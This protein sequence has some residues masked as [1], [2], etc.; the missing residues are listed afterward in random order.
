MSVTTCSYPIMNE[1]KSVLTNQ[2]LWGVTV[3]QL[4]LAFLLLILG[5]LMRR[6]IPRLFQG[7]L[8]KYARSSRF[9]WDN[10]LVELIPKPLSYVVQLGIWYVTAT[11]LTLPQSPLN[12][13]RIV[14]QGFEIALWVMLTWVFFRLIDVVTRV[15]DRAADRTDTKLDDQLVPLIRK[16]TKVLLAVIITV[17]VL[18][19]LDIEVTSLIAS[20]GIGGLVLALAAKDTVAN[21]FGSVVVFTDQPFQIGDWIEVGG[22]EGIV[23]EVGFRTT[24]IRKFDK[25][26]VY[27]P[28]QVFTA[29]SIKNYSRREVRRIKFSVGLGYDTTPDQMRAFLEGVRELLKNLEG[30]TEDTAVAF[31][32]MGASSLNVLVMCYSRSSVWTEYMAVQ[33]ELFLKIMDLVESMGLEI[34]FPT[35]TIYVREDAGNMDQGT[36]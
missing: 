4:C 6:V 36:T 35:Q 21:F 28:N 34:A 13:R 23:E 16:A 3:W 20:L 5:L 2:I 31:N 22:V 25:S 30:I 27:M 15:L 8:S 12:I 19:N 14:F 33:Q 1:F 29:S 24:L 26:L 32:E 10:D 9:H 11:V 17:M 7:L 18:Q